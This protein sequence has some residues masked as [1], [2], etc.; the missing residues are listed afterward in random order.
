MSLQRF[1]PNSEI[2]M[3]T[4]IPRKNDELK[5]DIRMVNEFLLGSKRRLRITLLD[6][7]AVHSSMCYDRKHINHDGLRILISAARFTF[8]GVFPGDV[9]Q[10]QGNRDRGNHGGG[11][12]YG[13]RR[14]Y[15]GNGRG[16]GRGRG[17]GGWDQD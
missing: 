17:R 1:F 2:T 16:G 4:I 7:G 6:L 11:G 9:S 8:T 5:D 12:R 13:Q 10:N 15:R 3:C 14:Y